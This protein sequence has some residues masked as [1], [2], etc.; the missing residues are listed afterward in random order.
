MTPEFLEAVRPFGV[1]GLALIVFYFLFRQVGFDPIRVSQKHGVVVVITFLILVAAITAFSLWIYGSG[2]EQE[3]KTSWIQG[4]SRLSA[5]F[6]LNSDDSGREVVIFTSL[7]E[8]NNFV[9]PT[10]LSAD[11]DLALAELICAK[12]PCLVCETSTKDAKRTIDIR[13]LPSLVNL[14][15]GNVYCK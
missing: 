13:I 3:K 8:T 12:N 15:G 6:N 5:F 4:G 10:D 11:N 14:D 2:A 1:A 9:V 7:K